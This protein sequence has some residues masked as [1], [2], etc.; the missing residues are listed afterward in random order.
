VLEITRVKGESDFEGYKDAI[1]VSS[2]TLSQSNAKGGSL[3]SFSPITVTRRLN[4]A[5]IALVDAVVDKGLPDWKL[6]L[7]EQNDDKKTVSM[8]LELCDAHVTSFQISG[9]G[10]RPYEQV[11]FAYGGYRL[12]VTDNGSK[13]PSTLVYTRSENGI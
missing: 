4:R 13:D 8:T 11:V 10:N 7:L 12:G 6:S 2:F 3:A 5:T 9:D 1:G